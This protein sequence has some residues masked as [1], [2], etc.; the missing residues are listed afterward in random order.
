MKKQQR[1]YAEGNNGRVVL[2]FFC[3]RISPKTQGK[4]RMDD[5]RSLLPG[6]FLH[7]FFR[8]ERCSIF[9]ERVIVTSPCVHLRFMKSYGYLRRLT[10]LSFL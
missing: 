10:Y 9:M 4:R 1:G 8:R 5:M 7:T 6:Q 2:S 3:F